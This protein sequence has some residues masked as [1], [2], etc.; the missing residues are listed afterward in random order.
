LDFIGLRARRRG[1]LSLST[2]TWPMLSRAIYEG[3]RKI[4][5][6]RLKHDSRD[7]CIHW[8]GEASSI[9]F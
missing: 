7:P 3:I 6:Y 5:V 2:V 8:I 1:P 9:Q 4:D